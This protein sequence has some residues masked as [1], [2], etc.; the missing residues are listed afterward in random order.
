MEAA[1][2]KEVALSGWDPAEAVT[3]RED[4]VAFLEAGLGQNDPDFLLR[5]IGYVLRSKGMS[6]VAGELSL[7]DKSL[8]ELIAPEGNLSLASAFRLVDLLGLKIR[9]EGKTAF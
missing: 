7:N 2:K 3:T 6:L 8:C 1:A 9:L 5:T 4:V